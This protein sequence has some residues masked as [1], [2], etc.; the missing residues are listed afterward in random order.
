M[1]YELNIDKLDLVKIDAEGCEEII[2][3]TCAPNLEKLQPRT[4]LFEELDKSSVRDILS[5][6]GYRVFGIKKLLHKLE[7]HPATLTSNFH[8]YIA[9]SRKR[10]IP[11]AAKSTYKCGPI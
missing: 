7:L 2:L 10:P 8:D 11:S 1:F 5:G 9:L 4:I 6:I 3:R